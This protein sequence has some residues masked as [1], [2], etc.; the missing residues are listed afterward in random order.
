MNQEKIELMTKLSLYESGQEKE[1]IRITSYFKKDFVSFQTLISCL[2]VTVGYL[3]I[4]AVVA[5]T[6]MDEL[7]NN[8]SINRVIQLFSYVIIGYAILLVIYIIA[9]S[10]VYG[11]RHKRAKK[12]IKRYYRDISRLERLL[13][14]ENNE[15]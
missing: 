1:D 5:L 6:Y 3:I 2:W 11:G 12:R 14:K 4:V 7:I 15:A 13:K 10:F 9:C 8:I